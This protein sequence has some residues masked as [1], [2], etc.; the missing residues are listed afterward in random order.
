LS[1]RGPFGVG[2]DVAASTSLATL[3]DEVVA[4]AGQLACEQYP[5]HTDPCWRLI[6]DQPAGVYIAV[7]INYAC[8]ADSKEA[9]AIAGS[10]LY[11]IHWIGNAQGPCNAALARPEWRLY[12]AS[13]NDLPASGTVTVRLELQGTGHGEVDATVP[14]T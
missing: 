13:R 9:V 2:P 6:P 8:R 12:W 4:R 11:F 5:N 3:R 10:T 14:L 1:A 7:I